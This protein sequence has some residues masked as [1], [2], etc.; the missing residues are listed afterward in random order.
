MSAVVD[1]ADP[2]A[3]I[4]FL[5][6]TGQMCTDL[7]QEF[8]LLSDVFGVSALVDTLNHSKPEGATEATV[9]GPFFVEDAREIQNG[10]SIASD[11]KGEPMIV[12]GRVVDMEGKPIPN[13]RIETW[14]TD[15]D[16]Y[17]DTQYGEY[18]QDCRG[19]LHTDKD[20]NYAFRCVYPVAYPIPN[21]GPVGQMLRSMNR[22]VFRPA[23][24]HMMFQ[25]EGF[26]E[27]IT[28]LYFEGDIFLTSDAVFGVKSSLITDPKKVEDEAEAKKYGFKKA[29][30][31]ELNKD[32]VLITTDQAK[33]QLEKARA[34]VKREFES[35]LKTL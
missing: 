20:G 26:E 32:F 13:C 17:Y 9:L 5:T 16:G 8:I 23:H 15:N 24:L 10:E 2:R 4:Q 19:R 33:V 29:P 31:F 25:A 27:L 12:K 18:D 11:D 30:F 22:H 21:D 34:E 28:S 14:E 3:G 7:R 35:E 1:G 6:K